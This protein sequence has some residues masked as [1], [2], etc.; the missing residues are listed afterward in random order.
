MRQILGVLALFFFC[1][2]YNV[3]QINLSV[4]HKNA[5][6]IVEW[7]ALLALAEMIKSLIM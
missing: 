3:I 5:L 6:N 7:I 1:I 2:R 4:L